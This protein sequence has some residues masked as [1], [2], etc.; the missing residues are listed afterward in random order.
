MVDSWKDLYLL[1]VGGLLY[2]GVIVVLKQTF[3]S[4]TLQNIDAPI[5]TYLF[6][7]VHRHLH[8]LS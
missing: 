4:L 8:V 7:S 1:M 2:Q 5:S 6:P 3:G